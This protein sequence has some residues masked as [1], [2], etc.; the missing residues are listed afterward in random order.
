M[1][2]ETKHGIASLSLS[3]EK[4]KEILSRCFRMVDYLNDMATDII[5]EFINN[6]SCPVAK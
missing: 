6:T 3:A 2:D 5:M 1:E 4:E